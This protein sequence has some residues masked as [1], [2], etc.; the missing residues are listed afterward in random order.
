MGREVRYRMRTFVLAVAV[1]VVGAPA[2]GAPPVLTLVPTV[3][4]PVQGDLVRVSAKTDAGAVVKWKVLG[5]WQYAADSDGKSVVVVCKSGRLDVLAVAVIDVDGKAEVSEFVTLTFN[6]GS[7]PPGPGPGPTPVVPVT[8]SK[9]QI[10]IVEETSDAAAGRGAMFA[11]ATLGA[12]MKAKGHSWR[13]VDK[14]VVGPDRKTPPADIAAQLQAAKGKALPQIFLIDE[15]RVVR[16][17]GDW[18]DKTAADL[19][20]LLAQW[21]G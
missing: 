18:G 12:R 17:A 2:W 9:L 5:D 19:I 15:A 11:D 4:A 13:V 6:A 3:P 20:A 14:D 21:G 10:V 16:Y 1:A 8:P 7:V